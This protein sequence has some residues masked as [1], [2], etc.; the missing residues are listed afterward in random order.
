MGWH[1]GNLDAN[2]NNLDTD[3]RV[4]VYGT[5]SWKLSLR[6]TIKGGKKSVTKRGHL[7]LLLAA[8]AARLQFMQCRLH[9]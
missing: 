2:R 6:S 7:T 1:V 8:V 3:G 4:R 9:L 5:V